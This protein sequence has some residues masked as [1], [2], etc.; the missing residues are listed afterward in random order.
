MQIVAFIVFISVSIQW[1]EQPITITDGTVTELRLR[2]TTVAAQFPGQ[3]QIIASV[4]K[5][6][7]NSCASRACLSRNPKKTK[8]SDK[9]LSAIITQNYMTHIT[10]MTSLFMLNRYFNDIIRLMPLFVGVVL[11]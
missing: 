8:T 4:K 3:V 9:S 6:S 11:V 7:N 1:K 10:G 5:Q 2:S